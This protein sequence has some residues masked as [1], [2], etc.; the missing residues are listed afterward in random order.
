MSF[1]YMFVKDGNIYIRNDEA[2]PEDYNNDAE[3]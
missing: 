1:M 2:L 3:R